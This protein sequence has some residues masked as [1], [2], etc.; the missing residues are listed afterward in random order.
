[1]NRYNKISIALQN[2]LHGAKYYTALRAFEFAKNIHIGT[3][4]DGIT[5]EFQHQIEIALYITTLRNVEFE[6]R[7]IA[8]ALLHDILEDYEDI[9]VG[10]LEG[11]VGIEVS[12]AV[13][14]ISKSINGKMR[15]LEI[16][17]YFDGIACNPI[18]SIVKG[19]DRIHNLQSMSGIFTV[20]KQRQYLAETS[21][22]FLPML[23]RAAGLFPMQYLAYMNIRTMLKSQIQLLDLTLEERLQYDKNFEL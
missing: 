10:E 4:K 9:G 14:L 18:A 7:V 17:E 22:Y 12:K 21:V 16:K 5:P 20:D 3:R 23:K 11:L 8:V 15:Y 6:E 1:M 2:Y 19:A 13:V